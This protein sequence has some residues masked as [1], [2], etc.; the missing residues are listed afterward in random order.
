M[1]KDKRKKDEYRDEYLGSNKVINN[2]CAVI[3]MLLFLLLVLGVSGV[4][5]RFF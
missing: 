3:V 2:V 4:F 1:A 5:D